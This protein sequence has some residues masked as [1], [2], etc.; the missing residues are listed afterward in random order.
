MGQKEQPLHVRVTILFRQDQVGLV[1]S[2]GTN[3]VAE[4]ERTMKENAYEGTWLERTEISEG[5]GAM[6]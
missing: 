2:S 4:I 3:S 1:P 5:L 6:T